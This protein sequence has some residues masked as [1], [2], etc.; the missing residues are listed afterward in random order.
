VNLTPG[1]N[2]VPEGECSPLR[3]SPGVNT[4]HCLEVWRGKQRIS[5]PGDNFTPRAQSP[6]QGDNF[7]PGCQ[8]LPLGAELRMGLVVGVVNS[9]QFQICILLTTPGLPDGL[10]S[11]QKSQFGSIL[12]DP[13]ME[14]VGMYI[15]WPFGLFCGH[16]VYFAAIWVSFKAMWYIFAFWYI[17]PVLVCCTNKI[18]QPWTTRKKCSTTINHEFF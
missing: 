11:N 9:F 13:A 17:F 10:F 5:P 3:S 4:L 18:W 7:A 14:D 6:R 2:F 8:S 16:L 12:E 1:V 15:I